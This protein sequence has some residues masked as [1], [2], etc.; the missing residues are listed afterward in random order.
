MLP[1]SY[2]VTSLTRL[3]PVSAVVRGARATTSPEQELRRHILAELLRAMPTTGQNV[4]ID[5]DVPGRSVVV[6]GVVRSFHAKQ[7]V[8]HSCR[9]L[10]T[11]LKVIDTVAVDEVVSSPCW[12]KAA[13]SR[14]SFER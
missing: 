7:L 8:L 3:A 6:S 14:R 12:R 5:V 13:P 2:E 1:G 4:S 10:A 9:R 11:G